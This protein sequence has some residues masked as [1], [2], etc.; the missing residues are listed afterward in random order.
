MDQQ[1]LLD[2]ALDSV[3]IGTFRWNQ[4]T[5]ELFWNKHHFTMLGLDPDSTKA[6][7]ELFRQRIH[8]EDIDALEADISRARQTHGRHDY[9][10]RVVWPDGRIRFLRGSGLFSYDADKHAEWLTGVVIDVTEAWTAQN[11]LAKKEREL[12]TL[13]QN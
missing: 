5:G 10:F 3:P 1:Q 7:Y 13:I 6:T 11:L 9:Q 12:A 4:I 2:L 8:P